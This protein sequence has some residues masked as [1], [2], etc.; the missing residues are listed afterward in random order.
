M[1]EGI[2][3]DLDGLLIDSEFAWNK[4]RIRIATSHDILWNKEDHQN[5]MGVSTAVWSQYMIDRLKSDLSQSEMEKLVIDELSKLYLEEIPFFPKAVE[6][7]R[8]ISSEYPCGL[9]SG[10]PRKLIDIVLDYPLLKGCF[11]KSFSA[12]EVER[13]KPN[14]DVYLAT[15]KSIGISP[16]NC[17]C[18]EDSSSGI[19]SGKSAGLY[20]VAIPD[21]RFPPKKEALDA[22]D[23]VINSISE[24][25]LE[26]IDKINCTLK[27]EMYNEDE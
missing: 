22:A 10:S 13:G 20:V 7:V 18:F 12:D 11:Q 27:K 15:S 9:A 4:A 23:M 14:P 19:L 24:V 21:P 1:I 16:G 17:V 6:V 5:V 26:L 2:I 25:D 8:E 3:F